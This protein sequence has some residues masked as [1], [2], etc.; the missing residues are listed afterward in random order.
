MTIIRCMGRRTTTPTDSL[1]D[2]EVVK[3]LAC[4]D[5]EGNQGSSSVEHMGWTYDD[6]MIL[7]CLPACFFAHSLENPNLA[8]LLSGTTCKLGSSYIDAIV[9]VVF[10][11]G[12]RSCCCCSYCCCGHDVVCCND[13]YFF[14]C[15]SCCL[16]K[17]ELFA[18]LRVEVPIMF[19]TLPVQEYESGGLHPSSEQVAK[20]MTWSEG[21]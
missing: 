17:R 15:C 1:G 14:G 9:V 4:M 20:E 3:W 19:P 12:V 2:D 13:M 8:E 7:H 21:Q 16:S 11:I 6:E 10:V 5:V 18:V